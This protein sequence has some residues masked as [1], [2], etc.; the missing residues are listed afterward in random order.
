[1]QLVEHPVF[2]KE[3]LYPAKFFDPQNPLSTP[4]EEAAFTSGWRSEAVQRY[5]SR[6][7]AFNSWTPER[8]DIGLSYS[9]DG[10]R[11]LVNATSSRPET[12]YSV[13]AHWLKVENLPPHI[14]PRMVMFV[15]LGSVCSV[16]ILLLDMRMNSPAFRRRRRARKIFTASMSSCGQW[17]SPS[18]K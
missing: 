10:V 12:K 9:V 1:M 14:A 6:F 3:L 17:L 11:L 2:G 7:G 8:F 15:G 13:V 16:R 4:P 18:T 5:R